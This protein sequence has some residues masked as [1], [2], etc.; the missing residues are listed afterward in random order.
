[1]IIERWPRST[2]SVL[3]DGRRNNKVKINHKIDPNRSS[4]K[5]EMSGR[6]GLATNLQLTKMKSV[7]HDSLIK[8]PYNEGGASSQ[9]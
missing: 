2:T 6:P 3:Q 1:M 7:L 9:T 4:T 8:D 5:D